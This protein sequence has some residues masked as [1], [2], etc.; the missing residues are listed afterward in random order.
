[1]R[2]YDPKLYSGSYVTPLG[3]LTAILAAQPWDEGGF[4][5][6]RKLNMVQSTAHVDRTVIESN[7]GFINK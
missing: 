7:C 4:M 3:I 6:V 1:M 2:Y 5:H